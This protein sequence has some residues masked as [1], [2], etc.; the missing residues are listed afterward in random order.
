MKLIHENTK[1]KNQIFNNFINYKKVMP[2]LKAYFY[3]TA[4]LVEGSWQRSDLEEICQKH[5]ASP[6]QVL[7]LDY[8]KGIKKVSAKLICTWNK[9]KKST[10]NL[11]SYNILQMV[12]KKKTK[13]LRYSRK[14]YV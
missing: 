12:A 11:K 14:I 7:V 6:V 4:F 1:N 5:I 9:P 2:W 8:K 3:S 10:T 13:V